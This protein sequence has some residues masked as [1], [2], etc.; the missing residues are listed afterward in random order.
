MMCLNVGERLG[1]LTLV[2]KEA[3]KQGVKLIFSGGSPFQLESYKSDI[4]KLNKRGGRIAWIFGW[5]R[6][7]LLNPRLMMSY[8]AVKTQYLEFVN[9]RRRRKMLDKHGITAV[10]PYFEYVHWVEKDVEKVLKEELDWKVVDGFKSTC[11]VG[12]EMDTL[13]QYLFYRILG[14]NDKYVTISEMVRDGQITRE[15]A[16]RKIEVEREISE[17]MIIPILDK[18]GVDSRKFMDKINKKYPVQ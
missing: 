7:V 3:I 5:G 8:R 12:C 14:Y 9:D 2:E 15:E 11:R 16:L 6:Q 10:S 4:V 17:D 13:R 18:I 1:Y